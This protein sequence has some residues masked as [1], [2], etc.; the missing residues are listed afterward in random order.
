[1]DAALDDDLELRRLRWRC[2]RGMLEN[3]LLL[4]RFLSR[5]AGTLDGSTRRQLGEL[6]EIDDPTLWRLLSGQARAESALQRLV[7][8][9]RD[10]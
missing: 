8:R 9:I 4:E 10:A 7:E 3:D 1:M 2:R 5:Y 6:L